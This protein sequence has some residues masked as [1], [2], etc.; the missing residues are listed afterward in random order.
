MDTV[1]YFDQAKDIDV[2]EADKLHVKL[3]P[4][5]RV[6]SDGRYY[7]V[8]Y[9]EVHANTSYTF[10]YTSG[11]TDL[12]K[13]VIIP[14]STYVANIAG[15]EVFDGEFRFYEDDV[16]LS[17][18]PLAHV[19]ERLMMIACMANCVQYGFYQGD[20]TKLRDDL[21]VL[22]PTL[23]LSVPRLYNRFYELMQ[24]KVHELTGFKRLLTQYAIN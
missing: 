21:A 22:R 19:L 13:G 1:I 20:V 24:A 7:R 15:L 9:D 10:S 12:P 4:L 18:L 14:H 23:M 11:T 6:I 3:I 17:Y 16:Y 5:S 2:E 8:T